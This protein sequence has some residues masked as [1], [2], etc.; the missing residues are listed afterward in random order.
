M[1]EG[2]EIMGEALEMVYL[3]PADLESVAAIIHAMP[4]WPGTLE[5][6]TVVVTALRLKA[7]VWTL[8]YRDFRPFTRVELW[9]PE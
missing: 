3:E 1:R 9:N 4:G 6:A 2:L 5:D 8:N 7:P